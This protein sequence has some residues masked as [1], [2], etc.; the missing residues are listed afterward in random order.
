MPHAYLS[1]CKSHRDHQLWYHK[2]HTQSIVLWFPGL[3]LAKHENNRESGTL[4]STFTPS[5]SPGT[6]NFLHNGQWHPAEV[7][8]GKTIPQPSSTL[9]RPPYG[10]RF[11][12]CRKQRGEEEE[13]KRKAGMRK[14]MTVTVRIP[15]YLCKRDMQVNVLGNG[16]EWYSSKNTQYT[17]C[18]LQTEGHE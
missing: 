14:W 2:G 3:P 13:I 16:L 18:N 7:W 5:D 1:T 17:N 12:Q 11:I 15:H 6:F 10:S 8:H 9:S 4:I